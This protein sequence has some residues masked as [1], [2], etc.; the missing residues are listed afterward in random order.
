[1]SL[2]NTPSVSGFL[3]F[4]FGSTSSAG[5]VTR[6]FF[7]FPEGKD[8]RAKC[9][10]LFYQ[11]NSEVIITENDD[12]GHNAADHFAQRL[13]GQSHFPCKSSLSSLQRVSLL[14][15]KP[16][17]TPEDCKRVSLYLQSF[18]GSSSNYGMNPSTSYQ[19]LEAPIERLISQ[20]MWKERKQDYS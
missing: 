8:F 16:T 12:L 17:G 10:S 14:V 7:F 11:Q 1:M 6:F 9:F 18:I 2:K 15:N 4:N 5:F 20:E 13:K 3:L 19:Q